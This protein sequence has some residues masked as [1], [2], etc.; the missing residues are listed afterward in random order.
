MSVLDLFRLDSKVAVVTGGNRGIGK[1]IAI[2]FAEAGA[3]VAVVG[4]DGER[5]EAVERQAELRK[6]G[7]LPWLRPDAKSQVSI[8]YV[9]GLFIGESN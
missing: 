1:A 3:A 5:N 9:D 4:R 2:A 6:D 8:R 7:R